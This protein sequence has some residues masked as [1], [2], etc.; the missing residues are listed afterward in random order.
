MTTPTDTLDTA[1]PDAATPSL[2]P[3]LSTVLAD[4]VTFATHQ[5]AVPIIRELKVTNST[6]AT[7]EA[8]RI[9]LTC[10]PPVVLPHVWHLSRL[11]PGDEL[12]VLSRDVKLDGGLLDR[13]S[14]RM[15]ADVT[16][17][18]LHG[19]AVIAEQRHELIALARHEWGGASS[20]PELLAAFVL[21]NDPEVARL[22]AEAS[23]LLRG[24]GKRHSL[25][26]YQSGTRERPWEIA[27]ALWAALAN[28]RPIY[29]EPPASFER[30]GQKIRT[31]GLIADTRLATCLDTAVLFAA[32]LEQ[33][34]LHPIICLVE[35]HALVGVWLREATLPEL[36]T[37]DASLLRRYVALQDLIVFETTLV[38]S[39][40]PATFREAIAA[41]ARH[42][43][44]EAEP[45]FVYALDVK[46]ARGREIHPLPMA[47]EP[48]RT[49]ADSASPAP[50]LAIEEAPALRPIDDPPPGSMP[51]TP[52]GR[53]EYW[54]RR[55]LD[56]TKRNRLLNLKP[57][58]TAIRLVC[59]DVGAVEDRLAADQKLAIIPVEKLPGDDGRDASVFTQQRRKDYTE[60]FAK[61][62]LE[63][64]QL[65][66]ELPKAELQAGLVELYRKASSDLREGGANTLFLAIGALRWR[67][68]DKE[69]GQYYRAPILL[70]PVT[71]ERA[72]AATAPKLVRHPD[73]TVVNMTLLEMLRHDFGI[74]IPELKGE[75]PK[76]EYGVDVDGIMRLVAR[77]I[78][79]ARGW[80]VQG[81][82]VL[83]TF[84]FA[85]YLMWK[86]LC[87]RTDQLKRS[88]FVAHMIDRPHHRYERNARVF[89]LHELDARIEPKHL[90]APLPS[91]SSQVAA[92]YAS[93]FE[94]DMVLEGPPG[95]GKSQTIANII[96]QNLA[97]GRRVLFVA[98]K[99][100]ALSVV[101]DRLA[102]VGLGD[103]CLELHSNKA[104]RRGVVEQLEKAWRNRGHLTTAQWEAEAERLRVVRER[105]NGLVQALH[106]PGT[107]GISARQA[108]AVACASPFAE[109]VV[110]DWPR[111]LSS[112]RVT[113]P[114]SLEQLADVATRLGEACAGITPEDRSAFAGIDRA[115]WSFDWSASVAE[116]AR[117]LLSTIDTV[118]PL[119]PRVAAAIGV[120]VDPESQAHLS[121]L[122]DLAGA[123]LA[124]QTA[125]VATFLT[126]GGNERAVV[127]EE[128][129]DALERYRS[130]HAALRRPVDHAVI[131]DV[132]HAALDRRWS[133]AIRKFPLVR[134][135]AC[136]GIRRDAEAAWGLSGVEDV[137]REA[138]A[139]IEL[140]GQLT[141]LRRYD[142]DLPTGCGWRGLD[143]DAGRVRSAIDSAR[144]LRSVC[145]RLT[146]E[147]GDLTA[148][149]DGVARTLRESRE[150]FAP[151]MP[152]SELAIRYVEADQK[153]AQ[154]IERFGSLAQLRDAGS[155]QLGAIRMT[156][157]AIID[158]TPRLNAWCRWQRARLEAEGSGLAAV[159]RGLDSGAV[160]PD[161]AKEAFRVAYCRWLAPLL[162]DAKPELRD[163]SAVEHERLITQ[164]RALDEELSKVASAEIRARLSRD[165]PSPDENTKIKGYGVLLREVQVKKSPKSVRTLLGEM[166]P[167]VSQLTPCLLMSP[168]SVAQFIPADA[169]PFDLVIFDE[170]S[171]IT[172]WDAIGAIARGRNV[173]IVG[174]PR[175][176]PPTNF[177]NRS[178]DDDEAAEQESD[179]AVVADLESILDEALATGMRHRRLTGHY[180]SRHESLIAFSNHAYYAGEL[181]T[182]PA[183]ETR[184]SA[185]SL[186]RVQGS[187]QKGKDRTNPVEAKAVVA[188]VSRRLRDPKTRDQSI[189]IVTMNTEQQRLIR[190]LL[191]DERRRYPEIER[192]FKGPDG[193][194]EDMVYNLE[195]VQGHE[196]DVILVTVG[197][198]PAEP[199]GTAMSMNF[200]PLNK[201]GGERRLN[202]AITRATQ[203]VVVFASF[204]PEMIDLTRSKARAVEDLKH[205]LDF[206]ERGPVALR[207]ATRQGLGFDQFDSPFEE[208][209]ATALRQR[210]WD[211][212]TQVGVSRFRI[213]LG[214]VHPDAPG[215]FLAG[216]E[217]D[218]ATYHGSATARDRDRIRHNVLTQ[219]GWTLLRLWSTD[220]F[221]EPKASIERLHVAMTQLLE[222]DRSQR[223]VAPAAGLVEAPAPTADAA[224]SD[225]V[226]GAEVGNL[227][228]T[229]PPQ[230]EIAPSPG[231]VELSSVTQFAASPAVDDTT[232][233][234]GSVEAYTI[235]VSDALDGDGAE[236]QGDL[237][238]HDD[239]YLPALRVQCLQMIDRVGPMQMKHLAERI[240]RA[241]GFLRTG[242]AIR[243]RVW[244]AVGDARPMS[245]EPD[246]TRIVWPAGAVPCDVMA[247][248]GARVD[249]E[250][251]S[252]DATPYPER[253]GL[254]IAVVQ[255]YGVETGV[256]A[257]AKELGI[258]RLREVRRRELEAL[259]AEANGRISRTS[260]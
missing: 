34:G 155:L 59:P 138:K 192:A 116:A 43:R 187:Y 147:G 259:L 133:E 112:D 216:V 51:N 129:L 199:G 258:G 73:E 30:A 130:S 142:T 246:G 3:M 211:V 49:A 249:G 109:S 135:F 71:L 76:D 5:A 128:G 162:I 225:A 174:D 62:A 190:N 114:E 52:A 245:E 180:R 103:F 196:R 36:F 194:E 47:G 254:A 191:D 100:T 10:E 81:D 63:R 209:V 26:G 230:V 99:M 222:R 223:A 41:G 228:T 125:E 235:D 151:G 102:K 68:T 251:R 97:H 241:H 231:E 89:D 65:V 250:E 198:G 118:L 219:L 64:G 166:G 253:L 210:G 82:V 72:S 69:N 21:P 92:I 25:E 179:E 61:L 134:F 60:E 14:E 242:K 15:R 87:D 186:V 193:E 217:C 188:E 78:G 20:M 33:A 164:F 75:L 107:S 256:V 29:A 244:A 126:E 104:S 156:A 176:M 46:Q 168:M 153:L 158:R 38:C 93:G 236:D 23:D 35:G 98:E 213:D 74:E 101:H 105:L 195:T 220:Y 119:A 8:L 248:R 243:S 32:G 212:R 239:G 86:D 185:V 50:Q 57:G 80:S 115:E 39:D 122:A 172:T 136:R 88:A 182:Y 132:D 106:A 149:R 12:A 207:Q 255:A 169:E 19:T 226:A 67:P 144:R 110:L 111:S 90:L 96:A 197:Y 240:A 123:L 94:G 214:V 177:F 84:S 257:L 2:T 16:M 140:K 145:V 131:A 260:S 54:K 66:S 37:D 152:D 139:L 148:A 165:V 181:V 28:R 178:A 201:S 171:Q 237:R 157:Q 137:A 79:D 55:L 108:I 7:F 127:V 229:M 204:G 163:F 1:M 44:E 18:L 161:R 227:S 218:G 48:R 11:R 13:L 167:A 24:A 120:S 203:E 202:V 238:F 58:K 27:G 70:V 40:P 146:A 175:Q 206:A 200:G 53:I 17:R 4:R 22:M 113:S 124:A 183:A 189:G 234:A 160:H 170:A 224:G 205:Y 208:A 83:S 184:A 143:T 159:V 117:A 252:W 150:R 221:L 233:P 141:A 95:T 31:P 247:Y 91:D 121:A 154:A 85:K 9:E 77:A 215:R 173:I 56:L 6:E 42:I 232:E 45:R